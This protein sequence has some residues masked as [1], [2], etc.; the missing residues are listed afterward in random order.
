[1][2]HINRVIFEG[3]LQLIRGESHEWR[4]EAESI[5]RKF[6]SIRAF[7]DKFKVKPIIWTDYD[8]IRGE[9]DTILSSTTT[10]YDSGLQRLELTCL[11]LGLAYPTKL[12]SVNLNNAISAVTY[13]C[14]QL[15]KLYARLAGGYGSKVQTH[16]LR[17][18]YDSKHDCYW[19][20]ERP[21]PY[22]EF[23]SLVTAVRRTYEYARFIIWRAFSGRSESTPRSF[24]KTLASCKK[25]PQDLRFR[26]ESSWEQYGKKVAEYRDCIQHYV[27]I[28]GV[29]PLL[30]MNQLDDGIW[31]CT[32]QIPDNPEA[33]SHRSFKYDANIDALKY[34]WQV[35][36]EILIVTRTILDFLPDS[37]G[38]LKEQVERFRNKMESE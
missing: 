29:I 12:Y 4:L 37:K 28:S 1:M 21:E 32:A 3:G 30:R 10:F 20:A 35:T 11:A 14:A 5:C 33:R 34:G 36:E 15:A 17:S 22:F 8:N 9:R 16:D 13:H 18:Q 19:S 25:L 24:V 2:V 26:L 27:C 7:E 23:E 38:L 31:A 6:P